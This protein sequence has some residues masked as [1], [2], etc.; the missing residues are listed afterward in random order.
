[1][2][3]AEIWMV[4]AS[5]TGTVVLVGTF[6]LKE[7]RNGRKDVEKETQM[8]IELTN[9]LATV[10]KR[11]DDKDNGLHAIKGAVDAQKLHC[12][13]VSSKISEQ[14]KSNRRDIDKLQNGR[15]KE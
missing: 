3:T 2:F 7:R 11:L 5:W 4:I 15:R 8:K 14:V 13:E 1:M 12:A 6:V 10:N 9:G